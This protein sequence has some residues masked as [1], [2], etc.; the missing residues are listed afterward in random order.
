MSDTHGEAIG[1][2]VELTIRPS[3][4][5]VEVYVRVVKNEDADPLHSIRSF[6]QDINDKLLVLHFPSSHLSIRINERL[7][8]VVDVLE[9][10]PLIM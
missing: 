1:E 10:S 5:T 6:Y 8:V 2:V 7:D 4:P 9:L 3:E